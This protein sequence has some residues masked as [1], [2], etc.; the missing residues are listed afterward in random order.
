M[1]SKVRGWG[2]E[3]GI[4]EEEEGEGYGEAQ[5]SRHRSWFPHS[6]VRLMLSSNFKSGLRGPVD[7]RH[8]HLLP[9]KNYISVTVNIFVCVSEV[10]FLFCL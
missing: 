7:F 2:E 3:G 1:G 9:V 5:D 10:L 4:E 8:E 6:I